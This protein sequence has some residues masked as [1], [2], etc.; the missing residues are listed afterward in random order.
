M[1]SLFVRIAFASSGILRISQ[2]MMSGEPNNAQME[3][4]VLW[5]WSVQ[6][7]VP[8]LPSMKLFPPMPTMSISISLKHPWPLYGSIFTCC[9]VM[10]LMDAQLF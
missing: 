2:P 6:P 8:K 5:S 10:L 4:C 1:T 3:K 9:C 7:L